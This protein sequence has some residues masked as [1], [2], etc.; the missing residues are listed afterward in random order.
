VTTAGPETAPGPDFRALFEAAPGRYLVLDPELVIVGVSD[1][2][3][4]ATM[5]RREDVLG[6]HILAAFPE[7]PEDTDSHNVEKVGLSLWRVLVTRTA[8]FLPEQKYDIRRPEADGGGFEERYWNLYNAPVLGPDG[9]VAYIIHQVDDVTDFVRQK[10]EIQSERQA[11]DAMRSQI[12][13]LEEEVVHTLHEAS[14]R[15][16]IARDLHDLVIQRVFGAGMRLSSLL[17]SVPDTTAHTLREIVAELDAVISDIRTTI[18]DLQSPMAASRGLRWAVLSL[19]NDATTRLGF[20]PRVQ[21]D[22]P[23]DTVVD[24]ERGDQ[25]LAVL[26][27]ALSNVVRH[28]QASS[29]GIEVS[30]GADLGL[31][32]SDD[33]V[34]LAQDA[35]SDPG[36]PSPARRSGHGLRNM[37]ARAATLGGSCTIGPRQPRGTLVEWRVPLGVATVADPPV[38]PTAAG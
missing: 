31:R 4:D 20:Q 17:P 19:A 36:T 24:R 26:R 22:G 34:G 5:T 23:L 11:T 33:G 3:C 18:F 9:A 1:S 7:N 25:L 2:Y 13:D 14:D 28:A 27:E 6:R 8:D 38:R 10:V 29:V 35:V 32:V 12:S 15:E 21:F 30:V 16:R 37:A